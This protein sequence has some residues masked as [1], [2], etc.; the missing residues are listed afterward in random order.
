MVREFIYTPKFDR[1][2]AKLGLCDDDLN[3]L[4]SFLLENLDAGKIMEGTGGIRKM[5]WMLPDRG[6]SSGIRVLYV[7]FLMLEKICMFD[8]FPKDVKDNLSQSE[9]KA[10]KQVVK[11]IGKEF[12]NG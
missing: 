8:L 9:K 10:L 3:A 4:E 2:W 6:K 12:N 1:E 11:A 5:R 7:D